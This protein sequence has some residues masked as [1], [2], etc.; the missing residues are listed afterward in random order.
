MRLS[1]IF[2]T[3]ISLVMASTT[4]QRTDGTTLVLGDE[5]QEVDFSNFI[6]PKSQIAP[7]PTL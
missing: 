3:F 1:V 2:L 5:P 6:M 4:Y 7:Q